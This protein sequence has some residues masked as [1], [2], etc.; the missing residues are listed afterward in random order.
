LT[1]TPLIDSI[2]YFQFWGLGAL[3][4]GITAPKPPPGDETPEQLNDEGALEIAH[5]VCD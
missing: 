1:K 5:E 4:V 3:F 2:S